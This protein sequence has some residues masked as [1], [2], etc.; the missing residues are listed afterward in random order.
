MIADLMIALASTIF[1]YSA[2]ELTVGV[3]SP[4]H[5]HKFKTTEISS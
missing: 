5:W 1:S 4:E 3:V 2:N